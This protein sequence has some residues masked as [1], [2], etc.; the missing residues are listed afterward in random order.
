[1]TD[2]YHLDLSKAKASQILSLADAYAKVFSTDSAWNEFYKCPRCSSSFPESYLATECSHCTQ[3]G[4]SVPLV[5]Y[6]PTTIIL[7][8]FYKE[9]SKEGA[10]CIVASDKSENIVG[11]CWGY[12]LKV[13]HHLEEHLGAPGLIESMKNF[14]ITDEYV[15]YQDEIAVIPTFQKQGIAKKLFQERHRHF[16]EK[17]PNGTAIFRT[18]ASPPSSTYGWM[19]EK[20]GYQV[21]HNLESENRLRVIAGKKIIECLN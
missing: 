20:L 13:D 15:A 18:L 17:I 2:I 9:M 11:F 7:S 14:G 6:W 16:H 10:V 12:L 1:M 4:Y 19:I 21:I 5:P 8:D 3:E